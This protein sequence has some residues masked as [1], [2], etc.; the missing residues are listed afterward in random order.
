MEL[1]T[2]KNKKILFKYPATW[3]REHPTTDINPDCIATLSKGEGNILNIVMFPTNM[4]LEDFKIRMEDMITDD[5]GV[6]SDSTF[7]I[8]AGKQAIHTIAEITTP[9]I[10]FEIHTYV[11]IQSNYVYIIELRTINPMDV[12]S[13]YDA[14]IDSFEIL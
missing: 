2:F 13:E 8:K 11:F 14:L 7:V 10:I 4:T 3:E 12:L 9:D 1:K 5:G 6:I